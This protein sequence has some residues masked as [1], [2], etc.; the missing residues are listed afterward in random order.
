[1]VPFSRML[2]RI[3][4]RLSVPPSAGAKVVEEIK[5]HVSCEAFYDWGGGLIWVALNPEATAESNLIRKTLKKH[6]GHALLVRARADI[7]RRTSVF[8]PQSSAL[9]ALS[10]RIKDSFDPLRILNP[11]KMFKDI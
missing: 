9:Y 5:L 11:G 10:T 2:N 7:R 3:V 6:G 1:M 4:W 8:Q